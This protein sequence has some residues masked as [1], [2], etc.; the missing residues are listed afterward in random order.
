M[1]GRIATHVASHGNA[2]PLQGVVCLGY[3][4]HPP[5]RPEQR[6]DAHLPAIR[7]PLLF[8]QGTRDTFGTA[9]EVEA[10]VP[11][12][13]CATLHAVPGGDH[14]FKVPGGK[15]AQEPIF[16]GILETVVQWMR[17]TL[18]HRAG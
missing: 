5:G 6:R 16:D 17:S 9:A 2:G 14:S 10:L 8:I 4:L 13:Q 15:K 12:L 3:P 1:G 18:S 7:E 11:Q